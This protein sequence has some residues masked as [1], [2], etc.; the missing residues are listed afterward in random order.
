MTQQHPCLQRLSALLEE[1]AGRRVNGN[2]ASH[3]TSSSYGDVLKKCFRQL[4]ALG[5][6]IEDSRNLKKSSCLS[7]RLVNATNC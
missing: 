6:K 2:V 1:N 5:Y 3:S 4:L 7:K